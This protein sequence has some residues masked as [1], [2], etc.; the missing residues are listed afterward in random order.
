MVEERYAS[1]TFNQCENCPLPMVS[2]FL[3]LR[4]YVDPEAKP[5]AAHKPCPVPVQ[6]Q[7]EVKRTLDRDV[8]L[9][10]LEKVPIGTPSE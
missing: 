4:L 2:G 6:F 7:P 3:P 10:V 8:T 1:S 5:V 9:G